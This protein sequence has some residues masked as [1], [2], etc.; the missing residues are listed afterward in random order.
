MNMGRSIIGGILGGL[1][2]AVIWAGIS[3]F[4]GYEIGWIAWGVGGLVGLG[5]TWGGQGGGRPLGVVAVV[6]TLVSIVAG[7]Y[8]AVE[9][10]IRREIG[11]RE[12]VLQSALTNLQKNDMVVSYLADEIIEQREAQG[13][14]IQWPSGVNPEEAN[15]QSD[16]PPAIWSEA[17]SKWDGMSAQERE[18]YRDQLEEQIRT[19]IQAFFSG[20]STY[21]F[22]N[23]FG[24]MDLL[25][26]GLAVATAFKIA[27][28]EAAHAAQPNT[29]IEKQ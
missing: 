16:Y 4:T 26:F 12:E 21:G 2:G 17:A 8:A 15:Q 20:V 14:T 23:S 9:L 24:V 29:D 6:I 7:K 5:C 22:R 11:S 25:F 10:S 19:N 27:T 1:V 28:R 3:C 18:Q 13:E